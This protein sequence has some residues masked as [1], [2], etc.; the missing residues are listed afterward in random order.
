MGDTCFGKM[1]ENKSNM[2]CVVVYERVLV[3]IHG[4]GVWKAE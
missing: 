1:G 2:F 3:K 4:G